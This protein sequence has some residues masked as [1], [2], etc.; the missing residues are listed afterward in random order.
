MNP[1][2]LQNYDFTDVLC[3]LCGSCQMEGA[4]F[5]FVLFCAII[6]HTYSG[7]GDAKRVLQSIMRLKH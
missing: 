1:A 6:L 5:R 3:T 2:T 7:K 4:A